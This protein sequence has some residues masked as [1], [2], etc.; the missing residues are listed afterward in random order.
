MS[1]GFVGR[2]LAG[3]RFDVGAAVLGLA[4]AIL[5]FPL[6]FLSSQIYIQT[7]PP[8]L[9]GACLLYLYA[10]SRETR[11][12]QQW[13]TL[14]PT[15]HRSLPIL[16]F[17]GL[18]AMVLLAVETGG[19]TMPFVGVGGVVG[20]LLFVQIAFVRPDAFDRTRALVQIVLLVAVVRIAA[21][22]ATPGLIGIDSWTHITQ[23][24]ADIHASGSIDAISANKHYTSP[25]YHL[26]VT[27]TAMLG[28]VPLR[29]ALYLSLGVVMPLS[30]LVVFAA[31]N[32]LVTERWAAIG[33]LVYGLGDYVVEWGIHIIPTSMGLVLYLGVLYWLIRLLRS[34]G[35][36]ASFGFL[37]A[38]SLAI[39]L[40]HQ[41]STFITLVL[42]GA[43]LAAYLVLQLDAFTTSILD[44]NVFRKATPV[45]IAGLLVFDA[46]FATFLWSMTPYNGDSFLVTIL[47]YLQETV[48]SSAGLLNLA[49]SAGG[50]GG[51][52]AATNPTIEMLATYSTVGG[53]LLLLFVAFVGC[54]YV[55]H[56]HRASQSTFTLLFAAAIMLVFVLGLPMFGIRNFIPQRWFA[57]L[58]APL[59]LLA[60]VGLRYLTN[61]V[62]TTVV[63]AL[64]VVF[65]LVFPTV[66]LTSMNG[67]IDNPAFDG[68]ESALSYSQAELEAVDTIGDMTGSPT[69]D[70][71]RPDQVIYTDH[72][73]KTVFRRTGSYPAKPATINDSELVA[74]EMVVYRTEQSRAATY[75]TNSQGIGEIRNIEKSRLCRPGMAE[76]YTNDEVT[77]CVAPS[78]S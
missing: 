76:L 77:M 17:V 1:S 16:V 9:G 56:R 59:V 2:R 19:R 24:A 45:N 49:S 41:V 57:F 8:V 73:Y 42:L 7:I 3:V 31:G 10:V 44:P 63:V 26:L 12:G 43:A 60:I 46:G 28:D 33:A 53:F 39:I 27:A 38:C 62:G 61:D 52:E 22:Y 72:P 74:H 30:V 75:F 25:L 64:V 70:A 58:Y 13:P 54:L 15:V 34:G 4:V 50:G 47:S 55:V 66:M 67:A 6:R 20:T 14:S 68:Q 5:L 18:S 35:S 29:L 51:G 78:T 36:R 37:L 40:T 23:I 69:G 48:A 11:N 71:I 65:A 21:L 32:L